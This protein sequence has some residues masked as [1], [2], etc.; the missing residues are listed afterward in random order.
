MNDARNAIL[1]ASACEAEGNLDGMFDAIRRGLL[2]EHDNYELYYM[3]GFYY[4]EKNIN[5]AYL[6]FVNAL[7]YC[8]NENDRN[9]IAA[10]IEKLLSGGQVRVKNTSIIIVSYN[11]CYCMQKNIECIRQTLPTGTYT[12]VVVDNGSTD[13][14]KEWLSLQQD[15]VL[16]VNEENL[17]FPKACNQGVRRIIEIGQGDNDVFLLN[18]DTR[19]APNALFWLKMGLYEKED[20]GAVGSLS[21]YAGNE[22][23]V[24]VEF[25]LP[26]DYLEYGKKVNIPERNP[27]EERVRLSGFAMLIRGGLWQSVGG[28]DEMFTPGY[29]EDDDLSMKLQQMGYKLFLCKN[30][31]IYHA[32]SQSFAKREDLKELLTGHQQFF[33]RK[34]GFDIL[35][36][37]YQDHNM[38]SQIPFAKQEEFSILQIGC[39]LGAD[40][41]KIKEM[42]PN[43]HVIGVESDTSLFEIAKKTNIVVPSI[44]ALCELFPNPVFHTVILSDKERSRISREDI[45][46][47]GKL[48]LQDCMF[49]P[50]NTSVSVPDFTKVKL[51]VWDMDQ[52]FWSGILSEGDIEII[53]E[54]VDLIKVLTD[55]GVVNSISSKN[56]LEEVMKILEEL[57]IASYFVFADINW[58]NKGL[59]IQKKLND[60]HL[61]AEN[62]LFIDDDERNLQEAVYYNLGIMAY[63]PQIIP[64]LYT[65]A[66]NT[67]KTDVEHKRLK[68]YKVLE[69]KRRTEGTFSSREQFLNYSEIIV[70]ICEDC[71]PELDRILELIG[72]TNQ[73]NYT[74]LRESREE[75]MSLLNNSNVRKGYV[76]AHDR[77]G[78]YGIVGF[79]CYGTDGEIRHFL[80]SCRVVGMGIVEWVYQ[81]LGTPEIHVIEPVAQKLDKEAV[82]PWINRSD[83]MAADP[84][85]V[86][87][88]QENKIRVL[89]KGP[90]DMSAIAGYLLG[91]NLTTEFNF[92]NDRGFITAGQNHSMHIWQG[93][94]YSEQ[95]IQEILDDVPFITRDDFKTSLFSDEYHVICYSLL[96]DCH[97]GLYKN[98]KTG[99]YISFG[100]RNFDLTDRGN[101][102]GYIDGSIVNHAYPFTEEI[103]NKF[104]KQWEFVGATDGMDLLRNLNYMY[105]NVQG[106][107]LFILLLG[108]EIEYEGENPE[109]ANHAEKHREINELVRCFAEDR[110]RIKIVDVTEFIHSQDDYEDCINHYSRNVY[111]NLATMV[112][113]IIN[114]KVAD[115]KAKTVERGKHGCS[116]E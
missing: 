54:N 4:L 48:C 56:H 8:D 57:E 19:L 49:L 3:L 47:L 72:R 12:I 63:T 58:E 70:E 64:A 73:L 97:A 27:Y 67:S 100:S 31:F 24:D 115:L 94:V 41:K 36:Y 79:Y 21:N 80:F 51:V 114:E 29:F 14:V 77:F 90:C 38:L 44:L 86:N 76:R 13:G 43:A 89:L 33:I 84:T 60:M 28:M 83:L 22:Q 75:I 68:N 99:A 92:V 66:M 82:A 71:M 91:G 110:E 93:V 59:Q 5:Q 7:F 42:Y 104:A 65:Y 87:G 106:N 52:T 102:Q 11:T 53:P 85:S 98:K 2:A 32:G 23:Q 46:R 62:V 103:I 50:R 107:P 39:G 18:N 116:Y 1:E 74:K 37:A 20:I 9:E 17:G 96:P 109:F 45:E 88:K 111:Y 40:M 95:Q 112:V 69:E 61:R 26:G 34:Y 16:V 35:E 25:P 101:M 108:S 6:C 105:E 10:G 15:I 81:Y 30:S 78:D 113:K 55:C